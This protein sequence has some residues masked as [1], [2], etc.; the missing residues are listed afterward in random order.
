MKNEIR[1]NTS[2]LIPGCTNKEKE[3]NSEG[4]SLFPIVSFECFLPSHKELFLSR[5][6]I[7][8]KDSL[9]GGRIYQEMDT[10]FDS[11]LFDCLPRMERQTKPIHDLEIKNQ[12]SNETLLFQI[13][14]LQK[15]GNVQGLRQNLLSLYRNYRE[16]H[17]KMGNHFLSR[18]Q[19]SAKL[20]RL[21]KLYEGSDEMNLPYLNLDS[22]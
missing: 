19:F 22:K 9:T 6:G 14:N 7:P 8:H 18:S 4:R 13:M 3:T 21:S 16:Y 11:L 1:K 17:Q 20:R 15:T 12:Q 10:A 2:E 5:Y